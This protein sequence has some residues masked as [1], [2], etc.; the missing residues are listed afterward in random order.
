M[1]WQAYRN[2]EPKAQPPKLFSH[3]EGLETIR[4]TL[5]ELNESGPWPGNLTAWLNDNYKETLQA[6]KK[7]EKGIDQAYLN[8]DAETLEKTLADYK[9]ACMGG[10]TAWR[11][12]T[13]TE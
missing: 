12:S 11:K 4:R 1:K 6:I 5:A 7:A 2:S 10:L 13:T 9:R 8:Q 3:Q